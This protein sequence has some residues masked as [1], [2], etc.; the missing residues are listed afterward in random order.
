MTEKNNATC[1][2]CGKD[3]YMCL[4]CKDMINISPWKKHTDT[5]E[6]YKIYQILHGFSTGVYNKKEA[7]SKLQKVDLSDFDSL[8]DNI[9]C[10]INT[11]MASTNAKMASANAKM[12]DAPQVD[13]DM[14]DTDGVQDNDVAK[15]MAEVVVEESESVVE[16]KPNTN[17]KRK[18]SNVVET[19]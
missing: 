6:H 13:A 4:S 1:A 9:K 17:H 2:I 16:D 12:T 14:V 3:Y 8:R 10:L 11:I 18:S 15:T 19:E 7:K 5:S